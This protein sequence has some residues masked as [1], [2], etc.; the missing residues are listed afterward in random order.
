MYENNVQFLGGVPLCVCFDLRAC[1]KSPYYDEG[2]PPPRRFEAVIFE[3]VHHLFCGAKGRLAGW[4]GGNG[5]RFE[6]KMDLVVFTHKR[7]T[8]NLLCLFRAQLLVGGD[9]SI[10]RGGFFSAAPWRSF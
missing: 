7:P 5:G 3:A 6:R 9:A 2:R 8:H 1:S 4:I 10:Q